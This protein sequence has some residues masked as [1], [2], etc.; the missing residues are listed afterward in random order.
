M[1]KR[2]EIKVSNESIEEVMGKCFES[3]STGSNFSGMSYE[4]GVLAAIDWL[5][6][7]TTD[8]PLED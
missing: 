1:A 8:N 5:T 6:G 2:Y 4:Q 7:E 3:D